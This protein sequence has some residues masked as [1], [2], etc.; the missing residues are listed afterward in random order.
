MV[1]VVVYWLFNID[2]QRDIIFAT[3]YFFHFACV[4][5]R[6]RS[7]RLSGYKIEANSW[8]YVAHHMSVISISFFIFIFS[9]WSLSTGIPV[10]NK[11]D[12]KIR[13]ERVIEK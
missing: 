10:A 12:L 4:R 9:V 8:H 11:V 7:Q 1:G 6:V 2:F 3:L 5:I 13:T